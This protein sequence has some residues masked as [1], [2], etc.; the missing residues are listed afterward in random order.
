ALAALQPPAEARR[1]LLEAHAASP[2]SDELIRAVARSAAEATPDEAVRLGA[3]LIEAAPARSAAIALAVV[4]AHRETGAIIASATKSSNGAARLLGA[5]ALGLAGRPGEGLE[6]LE[7]VTDAA[8]AV[9]IAVARAQLGAD[10]GAFA[11][12]ERAI[13]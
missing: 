5:R 6:A 4:R 7:Q 9:E 2:Q 3:G 1:T 10:A 13:D 8:L 12:V 11:A